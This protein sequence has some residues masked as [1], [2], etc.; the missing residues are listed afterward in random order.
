MKGLFGAAAVLVALPFVSLPGAAISAEVVVF[1]AS[2]LKPALDPVASLWQAE[3]GN[4]VV[5]S[6]GGTSAL[7]RQIEQGAPADV[8]L[9]AAVTWMDALDQGGL[10]QPGSRT[11]LWGNSLSVI[12]HDTMT[13]PFAMDPSTDLAAIIGDEKLAMALVDAVPV[14]QYGKEALIAYGQWD[15]V[16]PQVVQTEDA[17]ATLALVASGEAGFGI[18]YAT[19]AKAA[20]AQGLAVEVSRF[21]DDSH[22]PILYPGAV[23]QGAVGPE[24]GAFLTFL[25]SSAASEVFAAQ[26]FVVLQQ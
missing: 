10:L 7:A 8:F 6:Y 26:G 20:E 17:R 18:V 19:D 25:H 4:S 13:I 15:L 2:S 22:T 3:T 21:P 23:L 12:A 14:G 24:A 1:A 11:D 9:S 5:I 16:A